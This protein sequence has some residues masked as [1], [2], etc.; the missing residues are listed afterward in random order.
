MA[1]PT[2]AA[3][4]DGAKPDDPVAPAPPQRPDSILS[5]LF[6]VTVGTRPGDGAESGGR[7][8][9]TAVEIVLLLTFLSLLPPLLLTVTCFSRVVIVLSFVRRAM[10]TP[11]LPPNPVMIGLALFLSGAVMA[12]TG[13]AI[14]QK[15]IE[16]YLEGRIAFVEAADHASGELKHFLLKHARQADLALF[17]ELSD[18]PPVEGPEEMPLTVA[19]PA[20]I[21]SELRTAFQMGFVLYLPFL[22]I[23]LVVSSILLAMGMYMLPPML[24]ATPLKILLFVLVDGW[25]LVIQQVWRGLAT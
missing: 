16:P 5:K 14:H 2:T 24:V 17:M 15:A 18:T 12:P 1:A 4:Q 11:E 22:V 19:V 23:D 10:S 6:P 9:S 25:G 7:D 20:F 8:L 13:R 21:V 3:A